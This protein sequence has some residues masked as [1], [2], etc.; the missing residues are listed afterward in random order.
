MNCKWVG[1][2]MYIEYPLVKAKRR[3]RPDAGDAAATWS[4]S[5]SVE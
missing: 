1:K 2:V 4:G 5:D 3:A